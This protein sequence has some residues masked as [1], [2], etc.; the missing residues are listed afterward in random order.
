MNEEPFVNKRRTKELKSL[1]LSKMVFKNW[2]DL[3]WERPRIK[4]CWVLLPGNITGILLQ[5]DKLKVMQP[6]RKEK[7]LTKELHG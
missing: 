3:G 6:K 4:L 1:L 7:F 2:L 5:K